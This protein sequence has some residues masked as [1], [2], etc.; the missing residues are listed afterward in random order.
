MAGLI[1][2]S[3]GPAF[4]NVCECWFG[5]RHQSVLP[6][7]LRRKGV[8]LQLL[9]QEYKETHPDDGYQYSRF[10]ELYKRFKGQL[11]V[12]LRQ[13]YRAGE[14]GLV[15]FSGDGIPIVC[16]QTGE[17]TQAELFIAVLGASGR[18]IWSVVTEDERDG[19]SRRRAWSS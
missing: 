1:F 19:R 2:A 3:E 16:P 13:P 9:W 18:G 6:E 5:R 15:D 7:E 17:V 8:T 11:D 12:V 10:C 14:K 4:A